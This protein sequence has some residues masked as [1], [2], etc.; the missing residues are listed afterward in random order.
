MDMEQVDYSKIREQI[1]PKF[2]DLIM[3]WTMD[4]F[5]RHERGTGWYVIFLVLGVGLIIW[6]LLTSNYIFAILLVLIGTY[7]ILEHFRDPGDV[8]VMI[9]TTGIVVGNHYHPWDEIKDFSIVYEP[10]AIRKM[11]LDFVPVKHLPVGLDFPEDM[12]P[13]E[14]RETILEFAD[15]DLDRKEESVIDFIRRTYKI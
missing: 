8:P 9:L 10:P 6:A 15:E 4:E 7:M 3:M 11:Y 13:N 5:H 2:G 14:L 12:N 1:D